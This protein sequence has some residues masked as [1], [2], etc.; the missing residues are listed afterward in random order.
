MKQTM[1]RLLA[2]SCSL[3]IIISS[4]AM[5]GLETS[6][7]MQADKTTQTSKSEQALSWDATRYVPVY[8]HLPYWSK[9]IGSWIVAGE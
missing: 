9:R 4:Y 7:I 6:D 5:A 2:G 8:G 1:L 3:V